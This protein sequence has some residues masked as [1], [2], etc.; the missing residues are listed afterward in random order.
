MILGGQNNYIYGRIR[1]IPLWSAAETI[2]LWRR[3]RFLLV[4]FLVRIWLEY[5]LL[6]FNFPEPVFLKRFAAPLFVFIF[7]MVDSFA[8]YT[9]PIKKVAPTQRER[10]VAS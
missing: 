5:A 9:V 8:P 7:G 3:P 2:S 4:D 6:R 1:L 10:I